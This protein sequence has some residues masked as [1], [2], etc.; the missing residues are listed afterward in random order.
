MSIAAPRIARPA[1]VVSPRLDAV[2]EPTA[3]P[4]SPRHPSPIF[5]GI[6]F[7]GLFSLP[8][9]GGIALVIALIAR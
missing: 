8:F 9:W 7:A 2:A 1:L 4:E 3:Q 6:F 5:R